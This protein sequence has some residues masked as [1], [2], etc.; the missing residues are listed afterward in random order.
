MEFTLN[1]KEEIIRE[2]YNLAEVSQPSYKNDLHISEILDIE[3]VFLPFKM[4]VIS[5]NGVIYMNA[6]VQKEHFREIFAHELCHAL[7]H[8]GNQTL[9]KP[10]WKEYQEWTAESFAA[11]YC[12]PTFMLLNFD[13]DSYATKEHLYFDIAEKFTVSKSFAKKRIDD[14]LFQLEWRN[15]NIF[16]FVSSESYLN[17]NT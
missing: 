13:F 4:K 3:V 8:E 5:G 17:S 15:K 16:D 6:D 7:W 10:L 1:K 12:I 14:F 11:H 9:L 2:I